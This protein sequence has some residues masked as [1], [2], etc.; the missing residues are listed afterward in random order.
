M[1]L[2]HKQFDFFSEAIEYVNHNALVNIFHSI[3]PINYAAHNKFQLI[4]R[5]DSYP[6][7]THY[8]EKLK[9]KPM[10]TADFFYRVDTSLKYMTEYPPKQTEQQEAPVCRI[11]VKNN[12]IVPNTVQQYTSAD[13]SDGMHDL[14]IKERSVNDITDE[15]ISLYL[16]QGAPE[17]L[18]KVTV[19]DIKLLLTHIKG[20]Q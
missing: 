4:L 6:A 13:L 16:E 10:S 12:R 11:N 9:I 2:I 18:H 20:K 19:D 15:E 14:F 7:Y 17:S 8:C 5:F 1:H 3:V